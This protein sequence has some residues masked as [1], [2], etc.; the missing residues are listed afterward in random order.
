MPSLGGGFATAEDRDPM[1]STLE[2]TRAG[3]H[4]IPFPRPIDVFV[5]RNLMRARESH[6]CPREALAKA[7]GIRAA[8]LKAIETGLARPSPALLW[9]LTQLLGLTLSD[10][11]C[12]ERHEWE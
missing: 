2:K 12:S 10:V 1:T 11:F 4:Q 3:G 8:H 5:G 6:G 7:L 9:R